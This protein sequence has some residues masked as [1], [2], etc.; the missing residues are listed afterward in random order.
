VQEVGFLGFVINSDGTGMESDRLSPIEDWPTPEYV[1]E[2]QVL[3][4]FANFYTRFISNYAKV[5]API[6]NLLKTQGSRKCEWTRNA[7]LAFRKLKK[8]FT[9]APIIQHFNTQKPIFLQTNASGFAIAGIL[10]QYD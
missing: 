4:G 7:E 5:T 10:N 8:A 1:R 6:S 2:V 9:E 3:L